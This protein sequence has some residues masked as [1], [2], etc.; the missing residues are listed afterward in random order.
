[1][2]KKTTQ[3]FIKSQKSNPAFVSFF[4]FFPAVSCGVPESPGNGSFTGNEFTLD[5]KVIYDC[6]E[7]F[8]LEASQQAT[9]VCQEDGSWSHGGKP[10]TCKRKCSNVLALL[11]RFN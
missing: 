10:P 1:M 7:G 8:E 5:S 3:H 11:C 2:E 6:N 4:F 9:A